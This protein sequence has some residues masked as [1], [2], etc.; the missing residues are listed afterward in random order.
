[1]RAGIC[2]MPQYVVAP[3]PKSQYE[4]E[5]DARTWE[6]NDT[7]RNAGLQKH[8]GALDVF[9]AFWLLAAARASRRRARTPTRRACYACARRLRT[10]S[11]SGTAAAPRRASRR[12]RAP[13]ASR[14][15]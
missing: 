7:Q 8:N 10:S 15:R 9:F 12:G 3:P 5:R 13:R 2:K 1:M 4:L 11:A 14:P 6:R